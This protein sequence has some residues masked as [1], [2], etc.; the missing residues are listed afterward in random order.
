MNI[1]RL[2]IID[3]DG[4]VS[5]VAPCHMIK[6]ITA[7]CS[8]NPNNLEE[9][10]EYT[11]P[12]DP[13]LKHSVT[14]ELAVFDEHNVEGETSAI[15]SELASRRPEEAPAFRILDSSTREVSL[16]PVKAGLVIFNLMAKRIIQVQNSYADVQRQDRGRVRRDGKPM[17]MLY[18]YRL[19]D[20][21]QLVP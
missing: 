18:R 12:Y 6:V 16:I 11:R 2:N 20:E 17:R 1:I 14:N 21:W 10:L 5:F 13:D 9:L 3:P 19:P 15:R 4:T 8:R 7:A